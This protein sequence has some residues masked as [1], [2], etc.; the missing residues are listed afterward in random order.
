M[1]W[2]GPEVKGEFPSLGHLLGEW[3]ESHCIIPDGPHAGEP[4]KLTGEMWDNTLHTYRLQ[5]DATEYDGADAHVYYGA[6]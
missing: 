5:P 2:R 1:P 6:S 4:F 3:I